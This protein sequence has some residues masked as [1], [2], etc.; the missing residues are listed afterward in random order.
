MPVH[1]KDLPPEV[2]ARI[3][4]LK[5]SERPSGKRG[6]SKYLNIRTTSADGHSFAS[7]KEADRYEQLRMLE[8]AEQI[9]GLELQKRYRLVVND[10][11][12]TNY[13]ADFSYQEGWKRVVEDVKSPATRTRLYLVKKQLM[14]ACYG[15]EIRE[16][17]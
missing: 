16:V 5:A 10:V 9:A 12:I 6:Q 13:I 14:L 15:I 1:I 8:R 17:L 2:A 4:G 7:K 11:L 3:P